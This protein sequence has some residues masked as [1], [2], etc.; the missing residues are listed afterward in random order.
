MKRNIIK[1]L[2]S[3]NLIIFLTGSLPLRADNTSLKS[4]LLYQNLEQNEEPEIIEE[5]TVQGDLFPSEPQKKSL[6]KAIFLSL[7]VPGGG[8]FYV[9]SNTR[10]RIFLGVEA[11]LWASFFGF[12]TYGAWTKED[13]KSYAAV[14]AGVDL[15]GKSEGF[16]EDVNFYVSRDE[17]NQL[18]RLYQREEAE[19]YPESDFWNWYWSSPESQRYYRKLRNR[20]EAAYRKALFMLALSGVNR[21]LSAIDT[22]REV[23][24]Y[25]RKVDEQ[26]SSLGLHFDVNPLGKNK[27][28]KIVFSR[29]F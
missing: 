4:Y 7:L 15:R 17:Y 23:R 19:I 14:H 6:S 21:V 20:S 10:A 1:I 11:S 18:A 26:F 12:R 16:F 13:Y 5:F 2:L 9:G 3:L 24:K 27:R 28:L 8:E 22:I 29:T 25:N